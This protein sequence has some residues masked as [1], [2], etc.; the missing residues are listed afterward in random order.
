M[1]PMTIAAAQKA[2]TLLT[3]TD[4]MSAQVSALATSAGIA[5]PAIPADQVYVS[6][7]STGM[8]ELEQEPGYPRVALWSSRLKNTQIEK[9]RSVS[10][11]VTVTAE[12]AA[13]AE[14]IGDVDTWI[15]YYVEA[16]TTVLSNNRGDWGEGAFY[17]GGFDV[18]IL[19]PKTGGTGFLQIARINFDVGV[20]RN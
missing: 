14:L 1:I 5:V 12:I 10:G 16:L 4:A 9:F 6:S 17:G 7:A 19:P 18:E 8:A 2:W 3:A 13:T 15:H 11:T 20:G